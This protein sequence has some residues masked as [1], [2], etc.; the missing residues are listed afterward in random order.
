MFVFQIY[1]TMSTPS[2]KR[3][4]SSSFHAHCIVPRSRAKQAPQK[5]CRCMLTQFACSFVG[6][7]RGPDNK[8][9]RTSQKNGVCLCYACNRSVTTRAYNQVHSCL[10]EVNFI[11]D[12]AHIIVAYVGCLDPFTC[13]VRYNL[14][15]G[16]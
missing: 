1:N 6:R 3:K 11:R 10:D 4:L 14:T 13:P 7:P 16:Y 15:R 2:H 5:Q 9:Y 8:I 12:L